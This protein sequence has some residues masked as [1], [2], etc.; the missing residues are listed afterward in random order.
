M[1][2][3]RMAFC[4][5]S[6]LWLSSCCPEHLLWRHVLLP[7]WTPSWKRWSSCC[8][9]SE[10]VVSNLI[11]SFELL[12]LGILQFENGAN[13][14]LK[15]L[16][17]GVVLRNRNHEPIVLKRPL[18]L[19]LS[20]QVPEVD[21]SLH[22]PREEGEELERTRHLWEAARVHRKYG[23]WNIVCVRLRDLYRE[24]TSEPSDTE[25]RPEV[26]KELS[27]DWVPYL[28]STQLSNRF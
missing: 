15:Q 20:S 3:V 18:F 27:I 23:L 28:G 2:L 10:H 9:L 6:A 21:L 26:F 4:S 12:L 16:G 25:G 13:R 14:V 7:S 8:H 19:S 17:T 5:C 11:V 24:V 22:V 1:Q